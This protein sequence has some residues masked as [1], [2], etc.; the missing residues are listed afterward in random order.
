MFENHSSVSLKHDEVRTGVEAAEMMESTQI[1]SNFY[2]NGITEIHGLKKWQVASWEPK[3]D[4]KSL[5]LVMNELQPH[6]RKSLASGRCDA[7][8]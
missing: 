3:F 7:V 6:F 1:H 5:S 4:C 8:Y 2:Y